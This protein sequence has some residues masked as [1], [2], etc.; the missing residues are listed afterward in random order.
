MTS[1]GS[2]II[3]KD[4]SFISS[5]PAPGSALFI[6]TTTSGKAFVPITVTSYGDYIRKFGGANPKK[7]FMN[8]V[9]QNYLKYSNQCTVIRVMSN[10]GWQ[11]NML[12][13]SVNE[14][15]S[16]NVLS[17]GLVPSVQGEKNYND[18]YTQL[19][20]EITPDLSST[21]PEYSTVIDN[22]DISN[23]IRI[24]I[25]FANPANSLT[26][27]Y[28][29]RVNLRPSSAN[30]IGRVFTKNPYAFEPVFL[31]LDFSS[32]I[33]ELE[34]AVAPN[35]KVLTINSETHPFR[36]NE[37]SNALGEQSKNF[38]A[39]TTPWILSQPFSSTYY[40]LFRFHTLAEGSE[41]NKK[42]K[43]SITSIKRG[44]GNNPFG[45]FNVLVRDYNDSDLRP[46]IL[47]AFMN[48]NLNPDSPNYILRLIGDRYSKFDLSLNRTVNYGEFDNKSAFIR[49][50]LA[51]DV[52]FPNTAIPYGFSG[53]AYPF[54]G[55][56]NVYADA[57]STN[58]SIPS[59]KLRNSIIVDEEPDL[60]LYY[61][62]NSLDKNSENYLSMLPGSES[63]TV[64]LRFT[65]AFNLMNLPAT[66]FSESEHNSNSSV[67]VAK[68]KFTVPFQGG[69]EGIGETVIRET[70]SEKT[71]S[72]KYLQAK[73]LFGMDCSGN[74]TDG[75]LAY[76]TALSLV[77]N[78]DMYRFKMLYL[79][80]IISSVHT[81]IATLAYQLYDERK[82]DFFLIMD[83]C[84]STD[85]PRQAIDSAQGL[86]YSYSSTYYPFYKIFDIEN[87]KAVWVP[88]GTLV[89]RAFAFND[90]IGYEW[91]APAGTRRGLLEEIIELKYYPNEDERRLLYE[92]NI[93]SIAFFS[94]Y[95][96]MLWGQKTLQ[97]KPSSLD[98]INVARLI[99]NLREY[100]DLVAKTIV[101]EANTDRL[102]NEFKNK[103]SPYFEEVRL[104]SGLY[105]YRIIMK[106][107]SSDPIDKNALEGLIV[108][109]PTEAAEFIKIEFV[110]FPTGMDI[111]R[112]S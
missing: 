39:A 34:N 31:Y 48:C 24:R 7:T 33:A 4:L 81:K 109:Q 50:E 84:K 5:S 8:Y 38:S 63:N 14:G 68:K 103:L 91:N 12:V 29:Y 47:E 56:N 2:E 1:P 79:P 62:F 76:K 13:L 70:G 23:D 49:V 105:D 72:E 58:Y 35:P 77:S 69:F 85:T 93:N 100:V 46:N 32:Y 42:I 65:P 61:G 66:E 110:V 64:P 102:R 89:P 74:N 54:N 83:S 52:P 37:A 108:I 40:R 19:S 71:L 16:Q 111:T 86:D 21:N 41:E 17:Y 80:G 90:M 28:T 87:N 99:I 57:N 67:A 82:Q 59:P 75:T 6:G 53:F 95:G 44:E 45:S 18:G 3:V 106:P 94:D 60:R 112:V 20:F 97:R 15:T 10:A 101:F 26:R 78:R 73:N 107:V 96:F 30:F 25:V 11:T 104:N 9:V 27:E 43:V 88:P 98:R 22:H 51:E 55:T 92:N 36:F